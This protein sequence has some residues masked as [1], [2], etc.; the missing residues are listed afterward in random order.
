M[1]KQKYFMFLTM[2]KPDY[3]RYNGMFVCEVGVDTRLAVPPVLAQNGLYYNLWTEFQ[4][5]WMT[6][7]R[8]LKSQL[9]LL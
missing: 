2:T 3:V 7:I 5:H 6:P 4:I 1:D 9:R 8:H